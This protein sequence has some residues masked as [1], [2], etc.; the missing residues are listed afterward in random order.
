VSKRTWIMI[1]LA[2]VLGM[3]VSACGSGELADD[4]TPIPTLAP[5]ETPTLIDALQEGAAAAGQ[6]DTEETGAEDGDLVD[7]GA[8]L[9]TSTCAGCHGTEDSTGPALTGMGERAATRVEGM[10]AEEYL[11]QSIVD[12]GV[13]VVEGFQNIMPSNYGEEYDETQ[14]NALVEYILVE[15]GGEAAAEPMET[16]EPEA[17]E[18]EVAATE[19]VAEQP[20]EE[21]AVETPE[22]IE[23]VTEPATEEAAEQPT[24]EAAERPEALALEGDPAAGEAIFANT[25]AG[26]HGEQDSAGPALPGMGERAATRIE[27]MSAEEYLHQSIVDPGAYLAESYGN[28]MPPSYGDQYSAQELA[29]IIAYIMTQ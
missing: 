18:T 22:A 12:P 8:A 24:E 2:L 20:T 28:I 15:S 13:H 3:A 11:H 16:P 4:L 21:A 17:A 26:C 29:D 19:E 1:A 27:G 23:E 5:G 14:L 9:F 6:A 7:V 25:C 10:S